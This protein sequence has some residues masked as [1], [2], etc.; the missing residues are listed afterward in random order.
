MEVSISSPPLYKQAQADHTCVSH[1][2]EGLPCQT[3]PQKSRIRQKEDGGNTQ[4]I[5]L[6]SK[7]T[8]ATNNT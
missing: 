4:G 3:L 5:P 7:D 6:K 1:E 8:A 2:D